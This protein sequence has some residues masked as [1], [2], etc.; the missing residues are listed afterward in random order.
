MPHKRG[1]RKFLPIREGI[2]VMIK[3]TLGEEVDWFPLPFLGRNSGFFHPYD[4]VM[5]HLAV[6]GRRI[7]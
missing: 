6:R 1:K 5:W 3:G 2:A 4:W 7:W